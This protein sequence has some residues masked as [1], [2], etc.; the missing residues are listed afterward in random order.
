[1]IC[2]KAFS[3]ERTV[4]QKVIK[5]TFMSTY[6]WAQYDQLK[7]PWATYRCTTTKN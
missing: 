7:M 3:N 6:Q 1:M 4:L 5:V 2:P